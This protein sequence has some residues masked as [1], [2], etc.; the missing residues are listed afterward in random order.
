MKMMDKKQNI[1]N[2]VIKKD[3]DKVICQQHQKTTEETKEKVICQI[4]QKDKSIVSRIKK[5]NTIN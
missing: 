1:Q 5:T 2:K 3:T 4:C